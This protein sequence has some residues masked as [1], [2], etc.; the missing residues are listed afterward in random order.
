MKLYCTICSKEKLGTKDLVPALQ[1]YASQRID[2][3]FRRAKKD[4][5]KFRILSG[6][7]GLVAPHEK[8]PFYDRQLRIEDVPVLVNQVAKQLAKERITEV[9]FFLK[10]LPEW[11]PYVLVL[12][13]ACAKNSVPLTKRHA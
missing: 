2:A 6:E 7:L 13:Q 11:K 3:I 8:I 4:K 12:E 5:V 1:R 10:E 9:V